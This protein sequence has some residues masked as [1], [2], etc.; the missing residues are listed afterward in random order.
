MNPSSGETPPMPSMMTSPSSRELTG[1]LRSEAARARSATSASPSSMSALRGLPPCGGTRSA[2]LISGRIIG[3]S[4]EGRHA[5]AGEPDP[6][7]LQER[8]HQLG[9]ESFLWI[10]HREIANQRRHK[11]DLNQLP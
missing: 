2:I 10:D 7:E 4:R 1:T 8:A 5:R 9:V 3:A 11:R 6:R